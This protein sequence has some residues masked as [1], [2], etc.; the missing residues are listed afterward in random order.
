MARIYYDQDAPLE[1]LRGKTVAV[2]GYGSQGHAH[3][4]NLRDSGVDV[5]VGLYQGSASWAKAQAD[6]LTVATV[7]DAARRADVVAMLTPDHVQRALYEREIAPHLRSG[8]TLLFAHGFNIHY[9]QIQPAADTDVVMIAPKSPGHRM[10]EL[11][12]AGSSVPALLAVHRDAT[13]QAKATALAYA[14]G[15]GCTKA[16][17]IETTFREETETDLFGEQAVLCGGIT[18]LIQTGYEILVEAGYA[19]E[20][21]YF[22]CLN[23]MKLIVDLI[24]EGGFS[25]MRYSVSDTAE[26]GDY[27]RGDRIVDDHVRAAMRRIL[28]EVQD[29]TFARE[30]VLENQAGRPSM[31]AHR[32]AA[33][34]HSIE[35]VGRQL[36]AM[37]PWLRRPGAT[38]Q[39]V[40]A[41]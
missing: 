31:T 17:V 18:R 19:P 9:N 30:W 26:Y 15:I 22:E 23:E 16:G 13:G 27:S 38:R 14:R 34:A 28:R 20:I 40:G 7:A 6:G 21:A 33:A 37:M 8:R 29:G 41:S 36:R 25:Y 3:A 35:E 1:P 39:P 11:F 10:R 4:L 12:V 5:V 32:R 2:I 24:Y